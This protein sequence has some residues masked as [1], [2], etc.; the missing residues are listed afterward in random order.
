MAHQI[1]PK[2][3]IG[4][5][6]GPSWADDDRYLTNNEMIA[7]VLAY[8]AAEFIFE[9]N[10]ATVD[11]PK[12]TADQ[13]ATRR[14]RIRVV[15]SLGNIHTWFNKTITTSITKSGTGSVTNVTSVDI[16]DGEGVIDIATSGT[17]TVGNTITMT[18][19]AQT[20]LGMSVLAKANV[21]TII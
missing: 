2:N 15:D 14:V 17:W 13:N 11:I 20:I 16:E 8:G 12:S 6:V 5:K 19:A 1:Y 21:A 9:L 3:G 10:A 4:V 7:K 18:A